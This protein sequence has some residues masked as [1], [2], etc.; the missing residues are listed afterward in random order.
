LS[1]NF[2]GD[3]DEELDA[4]LGSASKKRRSIKTVKV[5][6]S[7]LNKCVYHYAALFIKY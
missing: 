5:K 4:D 2:S 3:E 1:S 6:K 7:S